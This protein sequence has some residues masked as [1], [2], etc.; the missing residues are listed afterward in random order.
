MPPK[1]KDKDEDYGSDEERVDDYDS[2]EEEVQDPDYQ[3]EHHAEGDLKKKKGRFA[4]D[5]EDE[6]EAPEKE[7]GDE[8]EDEIEIE[9][10]YDMGED[11]EA[12]LEEIEPPKPELIKVRRVVAPADRTTSER[13]SLFEVSRVLGDRARHIDNKAR[14][15]V[16]T[17][18]CTSSLEIAYMELMQK[19]IPFSIIRKVGQGWVEVWRCKEMTIPKLPPIEYFMIKIH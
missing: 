7:E 10:D 6:E 4:D 2:D 18:N 5:D 9:V 1:R 13:M 17:T 15:N 16:D 14:P 19:R 12:G 3:E 8:D 11:E